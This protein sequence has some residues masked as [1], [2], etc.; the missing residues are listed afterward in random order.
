MD[1]GP[2]RLFHL[3]LDTHLQGVALIGSDEGPGAGVSW[4]QGEPLLPV[5]VH[6]PLHI[7]SG[8]AAELGQLQKGAQGYKAVWGQRGAQELTLPWPGPQSTGGAMGSQTKCW[9]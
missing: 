6:H 5:G 2:I 7:F 3:P 9:A 4:P 1:R 8:E